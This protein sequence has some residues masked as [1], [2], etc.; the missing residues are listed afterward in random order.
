MGGGVGRGHT[1][2]FL[3]RHTGPKEAGLGGVCRGVRCVPP[4]ISAQPPS[5]AP[6]SQPVSRAHLSFVGAPFHSAKLSVSV[7]RFHHTA[8]GGSVT[9]TLFDPLAQHH[10]WRLSGLQLGL[11][12]FPLLEDVWRVFMLKL[13][14]IPGCSF[15]P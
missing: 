11:G 3:H 10:G 4:A 15:C 13:H 5:T 14:S 2:A 6:A 9:R 7:S 12:Q 8:T 1:E